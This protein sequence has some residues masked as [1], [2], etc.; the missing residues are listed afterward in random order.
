MNYFC[1]NAIGFVLLL[2]L[3][4]FLY[5]TA[6]LSILTWFGNLAQ[7]I[8]ILLTAVNFG[9]TASKMERKDVA[10]FNHLTLGFA[11]WLLGH[12][13]L[14]YSEL[15]LHKPATATVTDAIWLVGYAFIAR[16]LFLLAKSF[17]IRIRDLF[18]A[19]LISSGVIVFTV[20]WRPLNDPDRTLLTKVIQVVF[21]YFDLFIAGFAAALAYRSRMKIWMLPAFGSL[22]IGITDLI[23]PFFYESISPVYRSLD[24]PLFVGYSMWWLGAS[25]FTSTTGKETVSP[26]L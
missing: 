22:L 23:F 24:I 10:A 26:A 6:D 2:M 25:S 21:P 20:L 15:L 11:I 18:P 4:I 5:T 1:W 16:A 7:A 19:I 14:M 17:Q 9:R 3:H 8:T 12:L 13:L